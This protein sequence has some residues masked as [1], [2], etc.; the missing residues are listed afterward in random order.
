MKVKDIAIRM[1]QRGSSAADIASV[2]EVPLEDII[3]LGVQR[4]IGHSS[5]DDISSAMEGIVW[6]VYEEAKSVMTKGSPAQKNF[7]M[8]LV[9]SYLMRTMAVQTPHAMEEMQSEFRELMESQ[10][11]NLNT[12]GQTPEVWTEPETDDPPE[13]YE[14]PEDE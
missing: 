14:S 7:L 10:G 8:R 9:I 13:G 11:T 3:A 12:P 6:L 1:A 4:E 2:L 5:M